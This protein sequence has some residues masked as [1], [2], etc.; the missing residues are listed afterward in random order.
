M[1][2][3]II[4]AKEKGQLLDNGQGKVATPYYGIFP[5]PLGGRTSILKTM[6]GNNLLIAK[7]MGNPILMAKKKG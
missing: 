1:G 6:R 2:N 4:K 3:P 5:F 7:G